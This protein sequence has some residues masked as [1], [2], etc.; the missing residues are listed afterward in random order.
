MSLTGTYLAGSLGAGDHSVAV[1][2]AGTIAVGMIAKIDDEQVRVVSITGTLVVLERGVRSMAVAHN[3][4]AIFVYGPST[5]WAGINFG[6]TA[7]APRTYSYGAAGAITPR[8]G[9]HELNTGTAGAMTLANPSIGEDG[10]ELN[11]IAKTAHAYTVT[12]DGF[13]AS[14][15]TSDVATFGGAVGDNITIQALSGRWMVKNLTNVTLG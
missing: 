13:N 1:A 15:T 12:T 8:P 2:A 4:G 5:D 6:P 10:M 7:I 11:I 9:I 14:G 3:A